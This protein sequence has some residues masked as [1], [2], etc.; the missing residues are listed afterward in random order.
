MS[1]GQLVEDSL[2]RGLR[3]FKQKK[4]EDA[5]KSFNQAYTLQNDNFTAIFNL[6]RT[7]FHRGKKKEAKEK[8]KEALRLNQKLVNRWMQSDTTCFESYDFRNKEYCLQEPMTKT[9]LD[10]NIQSLLAEL[11]Y[12]L[13]DW[14]HAKF[15]FDE[16]VKIEPDNEDLKEKREIT[17]ENCGLTSH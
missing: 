1:N 13:R 14:E 8:F 6:A 12:E 15:C 2:N 3:A 10:E 9:E 17:R 11:Y 7:L 5:E 16:A 4:Y